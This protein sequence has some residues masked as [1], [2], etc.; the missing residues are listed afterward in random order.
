MDLGADRRHDASVQV[1]QA[2]AGD[3]GQFGITTYLQCKR[4]L[5]SRA[6]TLD[7]HACGR[8]GKQGV[9][10]PA[11]SSFFA[12]GILGKFPSSNVGYDSGNVIWSTFGYHY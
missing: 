10:L 7:I 3:G 5:C 9:G 12:V 6:V 2:D 11:R 8:A 4:L 1:T